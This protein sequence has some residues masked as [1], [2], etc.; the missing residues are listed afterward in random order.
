MRLHFGAQVGD[1]LQKI[2]VLLI[3]H[4]PR[5]CAGLT[6]KTCVLLYI[7]W[8]LW[9]HSHGSLV[10]LF[11]TYHFQLVLS[12]LHLK[13]L[14]NHSIKIMMTV[15]TKYKKSKEKKKNTQPL[16]RRMAPN[17]VIMQSCEEPHSHIMHTWRERGS[18]VQTN[19][20]TTYNSHPPNMEQGPLLQSRREGLR[21]ISNL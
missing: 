8:S 16:K 20:S 6:T 11:A 3:L 1:C 7:R 10:P 12:N 17:V 5:L 4:K 14:L 18:A 21:K 19:L 15:A 13:P 9:K 2:L